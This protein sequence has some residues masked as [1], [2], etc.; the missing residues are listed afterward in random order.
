MKINTLRSEQCEPGGTRRP[1]ARWSLID[2]ETPA[3]QRLSAI[4]SGAD[5]WRERMTK[6]APSTL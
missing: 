3:F 5:N 6:I 2:P 4:M 1:I